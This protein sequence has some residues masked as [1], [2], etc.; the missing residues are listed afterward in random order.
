MDTP[1]PPRTRVVVVGTGFAG[2]GTAI[3]LRERGETDFVVLERAHDVGGTWRDNTYPGCACDVPSHLYSFSFAPNP[4]WTRAFSPQ[5]EIQAYLQRTAREHG[6]LP[7]V[8]FGTELTA[9]RWDEAAATWTVETSRG[10]VVCDVL[11]LGSGGLSEPSVPSLPGLERFRGTTFH[12]ATWRH[13]H[14]LTGERVAVVGTGA[15]AIQ[16]VPHVQRRAARMTLFQRTAPWVLPRR[17]RAISR[18]ERALYRRVP[19]AQKANRAG[20]YVS[21]ESWLLGFTVQPALMKV[22]EMMARRLLAEQ[23]PDPVLRAKLTPTYRLGCKRVL[24]SND[25][26]PALAQPNADVVTDRIAEVTRTAVVTEAADGT[27]VEHE[28]DTIVFGT[29]FQVSDP[30]IAGRVVGRDGRSLKQVW[31][32]TGMTAYH[33]T[34]V[35]GFPNLFFL[36]GPNT[37]LGHNSIVYMIESQVAYVVEALERMRAAGIAAVE[38]RPELQEAWNARLQEDLQGTVWNAGGCSSW[39]L[40]AAGRNT[41]LWPTFTLPYRRQ[42]AGFDVSAYATRPAAERVAA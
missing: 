5:P 13:D 20:L 23:V 22:G 27:R 6:V 35:A 26:Y 34:T 39:Y 18:A 38:P 16:F 37:G 14:D 30:P 21:R 3:R 29:G 8:R 28:V 41:T 11:V 33:G 2:L 19:A 24:L 10:T 31:A 25:Y 4:D 7:H 40:D 12:S 17:D 9:A 15:S 42:L 32:A 1:L 36:V